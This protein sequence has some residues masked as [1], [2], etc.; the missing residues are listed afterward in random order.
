MMIQSNKQLFLSSM[1]MCILM[2]FC[3]TPVVFAQEGTISGTIQNMNGN[4]I[5]NLHVYAVNADTV[6]PQRVN[7][8]ETDSNGSYSLILSPGNYWVGTHAPGSGLQYVDEVY[9]EVYGQHDGIPVAVAESTDTPGIDFVLEEGGTISGTVKNDS[10][11]PIENLHL[12]ATNSVTGLW[13]AGTNTKSDGSYSLRVPT[14]NYEVN[15]CASCSDLPYVGEVYDN[16]Y[17]HQYATLV[18]ATE[19]TDTPNINFILEQGGTI[20]GTVQ[21]ENGNPIVNLHLFASDYDTNQWVRGANTKQDGSYSIV[22]P[23]GDYR[24][25]ACPG[26][27]GGL[28]ALPYAGEYYDD[29]YDFDMAAT[30]SVT[31]PDDTSGIDFML[32]TGGTISG[33]ITKSDKT[34]PISNVCVDAY[35]N[36]C[37]DPYPDGGGITDENGNFTIVLPPGDYYI[38]TN[39]NCQTPQNFLDE[40]WNG[41]AGSGVT[42]C[43]DTTQVSVL[44][45]QTTSGIDL[46]LEQGGTIS[47]TVKDTNGNPIENLHLFASDFETNQWIGGANTKQDGSYAITLPSGDYRVWACP[48]CTGEL[49]GLPYAGEYYDDTSDFGAAVAISVIAPD[50]TPNIDFTLNTLVTMTGTVY[51]ADGSTPI[52]GT[53]IGIEAFQGDP[54]GQRQHVGHAEIDPIDGT[55]MLEIPAGTYYLRTSHINWGAPTTHRL[56]WWM[57]S[58]SS[59]ECSDAQTVTTTGG[60]P[61]ANINF[62]LDAEVIL[63][64]QGDQADGVFFVQQKTITIGDGY[65]DWDDTDRVFVD[66]TG[67]ECNNISGRDLQALYIAQDDE[68]IYVRFDVNGPLDETFGYK[69]GNMSET[70][71]HT[72]V[73]QNFTGDGHIGYY[74]PPSGMIPEWTGEDWPAAFV[75][76]DG[77]RFESK[78]PKIEAQAWNGKRLAAWLDQGYETVCRDHVALP[79]IDLDFS[80]MSGLRIQAITPHSVRPSRTYVLWVKY[81][82][83]GDTEL[84]VPDVILTNDADASMSL[85]EEGPF[86]EGLVQVS[87]SLLPAGETR[88]IPVYFQ[89]PA[90]LAS[91]HIITFVVEKVD[92]ETGL[93]SLVDTAT[94]EVIRP[95][96]PNAKAATP[97]ISAGHYVPAGKEL[98]Y[99]IFF[100]NKPTAAAAAQEVFVTDI[101]D[102]NL[103]WST[104]R[105]GEAAFGDVNVTSLA[106]QQEGT[107]RVNLN[108][109]MA[110]D[111]IVEFDADNGVIRWTFRTIDPETGRLPNDAYAGF[112]P[113]NDEMGSGEGHVTFTIRSRNDLLPETVISNVATIVFDTEASIATNE[114]FNTIAP[115]IPGA[116][117]EPNIV[118]RATDVSVAAIL[119]WD[120]VEYAASYD[121]YLWDLLDQQRPEIPAIIDLTTPRYDPP[122]DLEGET[123]YLWQVVAKNVMGETTGL[124]WSFT[125]GEAVPEPSTLLLLGAGLLG[126]VA[127]ERKTRK[128]KQ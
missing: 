8:T 104:L 110:V 100:E 40:W 35:T 111:I 67:P 86:Q 126:I 14:G 5:V 77:N 20:S 18:S 83:S 72:S 98:S 3:W 56:E 122:A 120:P 112:L 84:S 31:K 96:D 121:L 2:I 107:T 10:G 74:S 25:W 127:L 80:S 90:Y 22:V 58:E 116:P 19:F 101:L 68:N 11:T 62:Q 12:F 29:T 13:T 28:P 24:V 1:T 46:S 15:A 79:T 102:P 82:N 7:G 78:I 95:E 87:G 59:T 23:S 41:E 119:S 115:P 16:V 6:P 75:H 66:T 33:K 92:P 99:I 17:D 76:I 128:K 61:L 49:P 55:Y 34:T 37:G 38:H 48:D 117:I 47:G 71:D 63:D 123:T 51:E 26:C 124:T 108:D 89:V 85:S 52:I 39:A 36:Q 21:D 93:I 45:E 113:P 64:D 97:G 103:D 109:G 42:D 94:S 60:E 32:E 50:N 81:T 65:D 4:S 9:N 43:N 88:Y 73:G 91:H 30:V 118:D 69:F 114:V 54:C 53:P 27:T 105:L 125:T 44:K 70:P 106:G 57:P